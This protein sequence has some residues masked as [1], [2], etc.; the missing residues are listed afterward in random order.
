MKEQKE[1]AERYA[2]KKEELAAL[3]T[4]GYLFQ[5]CLWVGLEWWGGL[6]E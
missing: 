4:E 2:S 6:S 3:T 5:A 1:E